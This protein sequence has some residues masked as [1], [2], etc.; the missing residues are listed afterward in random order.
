MNALPHELNAVIESQ[1]PLTIDAHR[2]RLHLWNHRG[3]R[4]YYVDEGPR[5]GK[6]IVLLHGMPTSSWLYRAIIPR[7]AAEGLRV[8]APDMLGFGASDKP[9]DVNVYAFAQQADRLHALM[10]SLGIAHWAQAVHDLGGPW[11]WELVDRHPKSLN[12]LVV[13]NTT[14][15][16]QGFAPPAIMRLARS[17]MGPFMAFMMRNRV[18]GPSQ[19]KGLLRQFTAY[20]DNITDAV[21]HGY[22]LSMQEGGGHAFLAFAKA[23]PW[24]F[25]QFD[26]YAEALRQLRIPAATLWGRHDKVLDVNQLPRQFAQ[27]LRIDA[28]QQHSLDAGHFLQ[29]DQPAEVARRLALFMQEVRP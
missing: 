14:A 28:S 1:V 20:P 8:I 18:T 24:W 25:A 13:M 6:V 7:L 12:G 22:W 26:R 15:Y 11:T 21:V 17:P 3:H 9:A 16:R 29:E 23:F 2:A 4:L 10:A 5:D 19:V 27:D